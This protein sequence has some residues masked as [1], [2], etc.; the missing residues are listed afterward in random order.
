MIEVTSPVFEHEGTIPE[1][2][3][4]EGED[5]N[6]PL[7]IHNLPEGT[8]SLALVVDDPDA[9]LGTWDHWLVWN[10]SPDVA[11]IPENSVP[12]QAVLGTNGFKKKSYGGPCPPFGTHR[13]YFKVYAL[14]TRL[15]L[16]EGSRKKQL[17]KAMQ[18]HILDQGVLMGRYK[19]HR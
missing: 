14:D 19:K 2:Y 9:P 11:E 6:P 8:R 1:K 18:G 5:I 16:P 3:T 13:Y 4:C 12:Q 17:E 10:I 7:R 15:D